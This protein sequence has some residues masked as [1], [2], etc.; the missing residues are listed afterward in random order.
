MFNQHPFLCLVIFYRTC[1]DFG[2]SFSL[3][4]L[5]SLDSKYHIYDIVTLSFNPKTWFCM[6]LKNFNCYTAWC[7]F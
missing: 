4:I 7:V 3:D 2:D 6:K 1:A 5:D